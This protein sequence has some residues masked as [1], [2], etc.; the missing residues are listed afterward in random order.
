MLLRLVWLPARRLAASPGSSVVP[1]LGW[2]LEQVTG[3]MAFRRNL[4][5]GQPP[6]SPTLAA[7]QLALAPPHPEQELNLE[8][9]QPDPHLEP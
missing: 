5:A 6:A 8:P 4:G 3:S 7:A 2:G 1:V 9:H